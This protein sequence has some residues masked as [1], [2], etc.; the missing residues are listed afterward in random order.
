MVLSEAY[1][2]QCQ[3]QLNNEGNS[4]L[5]NELRMLSFRL[6]NRTDY[7]GMMLYSTLYFILF[8]KYICHS[9][10]T[11]SDLYH[12]ENIDFY[13]GRKLQPL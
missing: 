5:K 13:L 10:H 9:S 3:P 12:Y 7:S 11:L 4:Y 6:L 1:K 8:I 2:A